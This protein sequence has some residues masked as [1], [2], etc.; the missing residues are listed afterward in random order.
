MALTRN[1]FRTGR[2]G[3]SD[4]ED[5]R[6]MIRDTQEAERRRQFTEQ[7]IQECSELYEDTALLYGKRFIDWYDSPAVPEYGQAT[8]RIKLINDW[9]ALQDA[10]HD[11]KPHF[12]R[13]NDVPQQLI[14]KTEYRNVV[15]VGV[16]DPGIATAPTSSK[17]GGQEAMK[18]PAGEIIQQE[19]DH[20]GGTGYE[21]SL[22]R[23]CPKCNK[24][25]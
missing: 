24:G 4:L 12:L 21:L 25:E 18:K 5:R 1:G 8:E 19:C 3:A 7:K 9:I 10:A 23:P 22:R 17:G 15:F 20:C 2:A 6:E 11:G 14:T 16:R 13:V